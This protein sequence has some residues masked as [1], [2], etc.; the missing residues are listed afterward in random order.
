MEGK[1]HPYRIFK[2]GSLKIGVL[3]VGIELQGLVPENLYG[4]TKYLDPIEK[5]NQYA[6]ELKRKDC[7][8]VIC[9]SHLGYKYDKENRVSDRVLAKETRNIDLIIGGHT[10][11]FME[12]PEVLKNKD[13]EDI[14]INQVGWGGIELGRMDFIFEK[15]KGKKIISSGPISVTKKSDI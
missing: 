15:N 1:Y 6:A 14:L 9:L 13:G 2:K 3:G 4:A 11:T 5:A 8:L 10:H 12:Q 7:D